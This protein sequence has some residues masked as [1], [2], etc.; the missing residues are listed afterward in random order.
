[1]PE[2]IPEDCVGLIEPRTMTFQQPLALECGTVL[3]EYT[4]ACETYSELNAAAS[5]AVLVCHALSGSRVQLVLG[6][7]MPVSRNLPNCW[8]NT[9][10]IHLCTVSD[11]EGLCA[12]RG[13]RILQR[14]MVNHA[15]RRGIG[16]RLLPNLPGRFALYRFERL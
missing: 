8:Y 12:E 1:M 6:G 11:F 2:V 7:R 9:P 15:H 13:I 16:D 5:N 14:T 3:R 4:L 10:N